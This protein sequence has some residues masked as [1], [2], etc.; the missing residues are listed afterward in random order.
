MSISWY[1]VMLAYLEYKLVF[2]DAL[3]RLDQEVGKV[4]SVSQ[5]LTYLL[6]TY[7]HSGST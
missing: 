3:Y 1:L 5:L 2:G 7:E 6:A 4:E